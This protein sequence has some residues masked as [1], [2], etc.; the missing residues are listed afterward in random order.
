MAPEGPEGET[1]IATPSYP[2]GSSSGSG[3]DEG[4]TAPAAS[5]AAAKTDIAGDA[6][7]GVAADA[8]DDDVAAAEE[9]AVGFPPGAGRAGVARMDP[10]SPPSSPSHLANG[11]RLVP[12][13]EVNA[14]GGAAR[15][16][17]GADS[18]ERDPGGQ[19]GA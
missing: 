12:P 11:R 6:E 1:Y 18:I 8:G 5:D 14:S 7:F 17:P 13:A 16:A 15:G 19:S 4:E 9:R 10:S 2:P 3:S